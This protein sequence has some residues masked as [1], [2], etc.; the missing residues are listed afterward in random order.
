MIDAALQNSTAGYDINILNGDIAGTDDFK[1][2]IEV[3]LFSDARASENQVAVPQF[4]RGWIGDVATPIDG[5]NY[6]S[7]LW[8]VMQER[9]TQG[10][11]NKCVSFARQALQWM[12]DQDIAINV[13]VS[14]AIVPPEG[15]A[16]NIIITSKSGVTETHYVELWEATQNN[17]N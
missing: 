13:E 17:A 9:L 6:G 5:Q 3:S 8:L 12:I 11:L 1:T 16:L 14:G 15:I 10:T 4:R 7:L 2:A